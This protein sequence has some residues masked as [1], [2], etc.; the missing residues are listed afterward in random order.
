M[1]AIGVGVL[2]AVQA[3]V[4]GAL[5]TALTS[6]T[7][8]AAVSFGLGLVVVCIAAG[9]QPRVRAGLGRLAR[10]VVT[11][12]FPWWGLLGGGCGA[13]VVFGQSLVVPVVGVALFTVS[14]VTGQLLGG[15]AMDAVGAFGTKRRPVTVQRSIGVVVAIAA[16]SL[17]AVGAQLRPA[18]VPLLV[19]SAVAGAL[20]AVQMGLTGQVEHAS[21]NGLV[22]TVV[23]FVVGF[24]LLA[25]ASAVAVLTGAVEVRPAATEWWQ[26]LGGPLGVVFI[27]MIAL[28]VRRLGVLLLTL[29][30]VGGQLLGSVVLDAIAGDA[31]PAMAWGVPLVFVGI[32]LVHLDG[33]FRT[34]RS[35]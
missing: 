12:R 5:A 23:N 3:R 30:L 11:G 10:R 7:H 21:G 34:R 9:V 22:A 31:S 20:A 26:Y 1:L 35:R 29:G 2:I 13:L 28:V 19:L 17:L 27:L 4:N 14:V 32:A 33:K 16:L 6:G 8:A 25:A 24:T 15:L 18:E